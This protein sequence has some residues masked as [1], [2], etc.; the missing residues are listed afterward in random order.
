MEANDFITKLKANGSE[1]DVHDL[2]S[3]TADY[4]AI[5]AK[6]PSK[7][8]GPFS[9]NVL[10]IL[11]RNLDKVPSWS[12]KIDCKELL[13]LSLDCVRETRGLER[14]ERVK[15]L[16]CVYH[17][18]KHVV[19]QP[20][21]P[22]PELV[23]KLSYM[24]FECDSE[25]ILTEYC[26][27]Y[28]NLLADRFMFIEKLKTGR[29]AIIKLLPKLTEDILKV[30]QMYDSIQ[31]CHTILVFVL[32]K[33]HFLYNCEYAKDLNGVFGKIFESLSS[34]KDAKQFKKLSEKEILE[35][36]VKFNDSFYVI[37]ENATKLQFKDSCLNAAVRTSISFLGHAPDMFHCLQTFYLNSFCC[38]LTEQNSPTFSE[39]V[40]NSLIIS[41][42]TTE[43]LGYFKAMKATYPYINQMLRLY[44]EYSLSKTREF[45]EDSQEN[46]LKLI[47]LLLDKLQNTAQLLKCD[48]CKIKSGL[49]D[50]LRLSF[51]AKNFISSSLNANLKITKI[52]P[53]YHTI[54]AKQHAILTELCRLGCLNHEK[55]LRKLQTDIHNTAILLN[56]AEHYA[57]AITL[58]DLYLKHEFI[59]FKSEQDLKNISRALY[60][61][62]IC[63]LDCK[64]Y[65]EALVDAFLSLVFAQPDGLSSEKYM[66]LVMDV[67]AKSLKAKDD[68]D[69]LQMMSVLDACVVSVEKRLYGN[70]KPFFC[71]L[72][73]SALLKHEYSM[74]AKLWPS[75]VPIA[76]VWTALYK[77]TRG[78]QPSW[79]IA[80]P[81]TLDTLYTIIM[82]TP[83]HVRTIHNA[84]YSDIVA[85]LL[86]SMPRGTVKLSVVEATL[87]FL[88][89]E[90]CVAEAAQKYE[91]KIKDQNMDPDLVPCTRTVQQEHAAL[92]PA[93]RAVELWTAILPNI[94]QVPPE[95]L[96][97]PLAVLRVSLQRLL[98]ARRAH[99]LQ[100]A[101][102]AAHLARR[103]EDREAYLEA[104]GVVLSQAR[105]PNEPLRQ[106]L[107][108]G[109]ECAARALPESALAFMC[110]AA[111]FYH[112]TG[113]PGTSARLIRLVQAHVLRQTDEQINDS[114]A[115]GRLL[116][117]QAMN[118]GLSAKINAQ[119]HYLT[120]G[121]NESSW[122]ARHRRSLLLKHRLSA[123]SAAAIQLTRRLGL[124]RRSRAALA[125][126][127]AAAA[128][129]DRLGMTAA[130]MDTGRVDSSR[131]TIEQRLKHIIGLQTNEHALHKPPVQDTKTLFTPEPKHLETM[132]DAQILKKNQTSPSIPIE[133]VASFKLPEFFDHDKSCTCYACETPS[134][135]ILACQ[136]IGLEATVYFRAKEF[137]I[138]KNYFDGVLNSFC[139][140]ED[141]VKIAVKK[142][143]ERK[144]EKY[145]VDLV[146]KTYESELLNVEL[147]TLI[148]AAYFELSQHNYAKSDDYIY[149]RI[150]EILQIADVDAYM[151]NEIMN[152]MTA[153]DVLR[154]SDKI[155]ND[156]ADIENE[157]ENLKL[158]PTK[159]MKTPESKP[160]KPPTIAKVVVNREEL[161]E[162]KCKIPVLN[163]DEPEEK[164]VPKKKIGFKIPV[165]VTNKPL[166]EAMTPRPTR[167]RVNVIVTEPSEEKIDIDVDST[168]QTDKSKAEFFTPT[169]ST[170]DQFFTPMTSVK[171]YAKKSL[172]QNIVKN[173][174]E[175]FTSKEKEGIDKKV[176]AKENKVKNKVNVEQ[177]KQVETG[178]LK[179]LKDSR[180][181]RSTSPGKLGNEV[182]ARPRRLPRPAS[183]VD[184]K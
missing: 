78:K 121:N 35:L 141:K 98:H 77:M 109:A 40:L 66:S 48:N 58:F 97:C 124:H 74:Y 70:L 135:Y 113:Q 52:L 111:I 42:E 162:L 166:I 182:K 105:R 13:T 142:L 72:K 1:K 153:S 86:T 2:A 176:D 76:G 50:A 181:K 83:T 45:T 33:L 4:K 21:H 64:L 10:C 127:L 31:F 9:L 178:S 143:K 132:R 7:D 154:K 18:H 43:K 95:A 67:K 159:E 88:K 25:N 171:T 89:A 15:T 155:K 34:K 174:E 152:L 110:D 147:D 80:E 163:F 133:Y 156:V 14:P 149:V 62:S 37:T 130:A 41:C 103:A 117:A 94:D 22:P 23:L 16:A 165:P 139:I 68:D 102:V 108:L 145:V 118:G 134:C 30:I 49:H 17:L 136:I 73:F 129:E 151:K 87:L 8:K 71:T 39:T 79:I 3:V 137:D 44:I 119:R 5:S 179:C 114:I 65:E 107:T 75:I 91:W 138:A 164:V 128:A 11:C 56:K 55:C 54:I 160:L 51:L 104:A 69:E 123:A 38:I 161:P 84:H 99:A 81:D 59:H 122:C 90:Y 184:K 28:W 158:T 20:S 27:T 170:P 53:V 36:Y 106:A 96:A 115:V 140:V 19:R 60:N 116:D 144:F 101:H 125:S 24:P 46:C 61:K 150:H 168:P 169:E 26:K 92:L 120:V 32:K 172:R 6:L 82:D 148:E 146:E 157:L 85:G 93:A 29:R 167:S 126:A 63:E 175:E 47:I 177:K 100:L 112:N 180:L 57:S 183:Y 12:D 173:L 131:A